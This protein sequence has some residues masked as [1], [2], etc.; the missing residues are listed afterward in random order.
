MNEEIYNRDGEYVNTELHII[1]RL[2]AKDREQDQRLQNIEIVVNRIDV[3]L[4]GPDGDNGVRGQLR[5]AQSRILEIDRK[6]DQIVP[7]ILKS[8]GAFA[9]G[10]TA[11]AAAIVAVVS[12]IGG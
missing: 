10:L 9:V 11:A 2:E 7:T 12:F 5:V 8:I 4:Y 3:G 6:I 1:R